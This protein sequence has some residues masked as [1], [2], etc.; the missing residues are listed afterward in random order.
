MD[1]PNVAVVDERL[2]LEQKLRKELEAEYASRLEAEIT[3]ISARIREDN[4]K[5][6]AEAIE[7]YKKELLPPS[8]QDVQ[9]LLTQEY[10]E[11]K[12][13]IRFPVKNGPGEGSTEK[14]QT[15]T[16]VI[17][18][19]PQKVEKRIYKKIKDVLVPF[20]S[21]SA[22]LSMNMLEGDAAKKIVQIMNTFEPLLD[23]MAGIA[24]ISLNPYGEDED[25]TEDWVRD[26]LSSTRIVKIVTAQLEANRM[27]D[28]LSLLFRGSK[29]MGN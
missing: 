7:R 9:K 11:F 10:V 28:F 22:A 25:V 12:M 14:W 13:D 23:V 29:L 18:E 16:F 27:R 6:V 24:A 4:T 5:I 8:E 15:K 19:L 26:N 20:A 3:R 2:E 1:E 21:E 17:Q